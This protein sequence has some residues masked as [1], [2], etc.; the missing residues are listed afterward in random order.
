MPTNGKK[1]KV[2]AARRKAA[3]L[4]QML[5]GKGLIFDVGILRNT[6]DLSPETRATIVSMVLA[7]KNAMFRICLVKLSNVVCNVE[8]SD[9]FKFWMT[10][11]RTTEIQIP[12]PVQE[13]YVMTLDDPF[14][15]F[16]MRTFNVSTMI[17]DHLKNLIEDCVD[18]DWTVCSCTNLNLLLLLIYELEITYMPIDNDGNIIRTAAPLTLD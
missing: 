11:N 14:P 7:D 1:S 12:I 5:Q 2:A 9:D 4:A 13:Y 10:K 3:T 18:N 8:I 6:T 16:S 15:S 17:C